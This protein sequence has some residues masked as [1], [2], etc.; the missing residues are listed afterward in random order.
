MH[1]HQEGAGPSPRPAGPPVSRALP[2]PVGLSNGRPSRL[3]VAVLTY[4]RREQVLSLL[5]LLLAHAHEAA[6]STG[7]HARVLVVDN[8]DGSDDWSDIVT[9]ASAWPVPLEYAHEPRPGIPAAR[10]RALDACC[11]SD[12]LVFID[13]DERPGPGWL[14]ALLGTY[15]DVRAP[16]VVGA[17]V[18]RYEVAP[19]R[20]VLAGRFFE[21]ARHRT[22]TVVAAAAT[23]NLLLDLTVTRA[24]GLRFDERLGPAGGDDTLFTRALVRHG[25]RIVWC[26]EAV[27]VDHVPPSR[28]RTSWVLARALRSGNSWAVTAQ[29][30]EEGRTGRARV[31]ATSLAGG[32]SRLAYGLVRVLGGLLV[33]DRAR[34]A[35]GTRTAARGAGMVLGA[36]G[37]VYLEYLRSPSRGLAGRLAT[38]RSLGPS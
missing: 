21:R 35:S 9:L 3:T 30:L 6:A 36:A 15:D 31:R 12:L 34:C 17:I 25:G 11:D 7:V 22:G 10:N 29:L 27:V 26:D 20:W 24:L 4:R 32:C 2:V 13:D 19:P 33:A 5:P 38:V 28:A 14:V 16:A 37:L 18:P 8:G 1:V 23:S